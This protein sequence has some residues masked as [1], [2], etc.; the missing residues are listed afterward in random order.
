MEGDSQN[1]PGVPSKS[2]WFRRGLLYTWRA[3]LLNCPVCGT[4]PIFM[5]VGQVRSISN[6]FTPLDGCPRCGYPYDREPGYFLLAVWGFNY[7]FGSLLGIIIY[8]CLETF[9]NVSL[10]TLIIAAPLQLPIFNILFARHAKAYFIALDHYFDPHIR[11]SSGDDAGPDRDDGGD[12][13]GPMPPPPSAPAGRYL[14]EEG[15]AVA[16]PAGAQPQ[17]AGTRHD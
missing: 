12:G 14:P 15:R 4:K 11:E 8:V 10:T 5:P 6:W 1:E 7:G 13:P 9:A 17:G 3:T 16:E 2:S